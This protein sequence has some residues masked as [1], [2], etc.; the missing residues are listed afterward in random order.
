MKTLVLASGRV[1]CVLVLTLAFAASGRAQLPGPTPPAPP[2][3]QALDRA[4]TELKLQ[5]Q[6]RALNRAGSQPGVPAEQ[7]RLNLLKSQNEAPLPSPPNAHGA[8]DQTL[9]NEQMQLRL[10][11][12]QNRINQLPPPLPPR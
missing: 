10:R 12:E 4:Q 3:T 11:E 1:C 7:Q 9:Q 8:L 6:Q 2:N 5:Q